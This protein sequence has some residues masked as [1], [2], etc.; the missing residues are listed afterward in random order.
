ML[1]VLGVCALVLLTCVN[2]LATLSVSIFAKLLIHCVLF[3]KGT[4]ASLPCS[5][6]PIILGSL[7][8]PPLA[9][10]STL[11]LGVDGG[12]RLKSPCILKCGNLMSGNFQSNLKK[13][14]IASIASCTLSLAHWILSLIVLA[15]LS[16]L[17][18]TSLLIIPKMLLI[19]ELILPQTLLILL[20][21]R[22]MI[23]WI[24]EK[25]PLKIPPITLTIVAST[26]LMMFTTAKTIDWKKF[27]T[28]VS[29]V[30]TMF[31]TLISIVLN[32]SLIFSPS[33]LIIPV[34]ISITPLKISI[35]LRTIPPTILM[36]PP[37]AS[38][39]ILT[40]PLTISPI[41]LKAPLKS[42]TSILMSASP[43]EERTFTNVWND[44]FSP[45]ALKRS[46]KLSIRP[47]IESFIFVNTSFKLFHTTWKAPFIV[48]Q[49]L[50]NSPTKVFQILI[51]S[52]LNSSQCV[53]AKA[54]IPERAT[55]ITA[56]T[57]ALRPPKNARIA[58][59]ILLKILE[60]L[61]NIAVPI[62]FK[63]ANTP[64]TL[65]LKIIWRPFSNTL[66]IIGNVF[67]SELAI[68][69]PKLKIPPNAKVIP[70]ILDRKPSALSIP[71]SATANAIALAVNLAK[72]WPNSYQSLVLLLVNFSKNFVTPSIRDWKIVPSR[73]FDIPSKKLCTLTPIS[74]QP[75]IKPC[76][77]YLNLYLNCNS[78][79]INGR[80]PNSCA[81][82]NRS[83]DRILSLHTSLSAL[84]IVI[85]FMNP[86]VKLLKKSPLFFIVWSV[87]IT[88][89]IFP[90]IA[91][92]AV[93][94]ALA[95]L[96]TKEVS[97]VLMLP[98]SVF[99]ARYI[100]PTV[101]TKGIKDNTRFFIPN[102]TALVMA[103][104]EPPKVWI[105]IQR[106]LKAEIPLSA[107]PDKSSKAPPKATAI[108][109]NF[110]NLGLVSTNFIKLSAK[111]I[112][113]SSNHSTGVIID[114]KASATFCAS[115]VKVLSSIP[116]TVC[117]ILSMKLLNLSYTPLLAIAPKNWNKESP[118][119][120]NLVIGEFANC[121][122]IPTMLSFSIRS[123]TCL[124]LSSIE[125]PFFSPK[126]AS[127]SREAPA[128]KDFLFPSAIYS[129]KAPIA[130]WI[131]VP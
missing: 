42:G 49:I 6:T 55:A 41:S 8:T 122:V 16:H 93:V 44:S 35:T 131:P 100:R 25:I 29:I 98:K 87:V 129:F 37:S 20:K 113:L 79:S 23:L 14:L 2:T 34:I 64:G 114:T 32:P 53:I 88:S 39:I 59:P 65:L 105:T 21:I 95:V 63:F 85:I 78:A 15:I 109:A 107:I 71:F 67:D 101:S 86:I 10:Q 61:F 125:E 4:T 104:K 3:S 69:P 75:S 96:V 110:N 97:I 89:W 102:N 43:I 99:H 46:L 22:V 33:P 115:L 28:C 51:I 30:K 126:I 18:F 47:P 19:V 94:K 130:A 117:A 58:E 68:F 45:I 111:S 83:S 52:S 118:I 127:I 128:F 12:L 72:L 27:Q 76:L 7:N 108:V 90:F 54:I 50:D 73:E 116:F 91:F 60:T 70:P 11:N 123:A 48:S 77:K 24:I 36:I 119:L 84:T 81:F 17:A 31:Q 40:A 13:F 74:F 56:I 62:I 92:F 121:A 120:D 103:L 82:K 106:P 124:L 38:P 26:V 66:V 80:T 5:P 9:Y 1:L 112:T 57:G